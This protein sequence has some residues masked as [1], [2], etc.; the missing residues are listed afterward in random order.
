MHFHGKKSEN[1]IPFMVRYL[2]TNGKSNTYGLHN[3]FALRYRR[4]NETFY[5][6]IK[7]EAMNSGILNR[8]EERYPRCRTLL[9]RTVWFCILEEY[10]A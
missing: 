7:D 3:S 9:V 4:V 5:K 2:T 1:F 8:L 10:L 6:V